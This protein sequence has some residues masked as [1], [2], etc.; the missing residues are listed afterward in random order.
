M[1]NADHPDVDADHPDP[2]GGYLHVD[3]DHPDPGGFTLMWMQPI[4]ILGVVLCTGWV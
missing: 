4:L 1:L 3:A 2:G